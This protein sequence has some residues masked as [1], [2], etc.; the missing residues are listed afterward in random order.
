MLSDLGM[1]DDTRDSVE[2]GAMLMMVT[3]P[4]DTNAV[5]RFIEGF[6]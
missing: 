3:N 5:R 1:H 4:K 2:I 6:N